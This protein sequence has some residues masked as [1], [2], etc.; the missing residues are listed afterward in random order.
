[1][2][3][4]FVLNPIHTNRREPRHYK[5]QQHII[6]KDGILL[7]WTMRKNDS[8]RMLMPLRNLTLNN[9]S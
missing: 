2:H 4:D 1:M 3:D 7:E 6:T 8:M 9:G 5:Q